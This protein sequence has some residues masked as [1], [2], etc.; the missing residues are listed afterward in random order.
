M[1][2]VGLG[3]GANAQQLTFG[4]KGGLNFATVTNMGIYDSQYDL[5]FNAGVFAEYKFDQFFGIAPEVVYSRQGVFFGT[6][7]LGLGP[8]ASVKLD[9]INVPVLVKLYPAKWLSIDLGPQL[10]LLTAANIKIGDAAAT[11]SKAYF[12]KVDFGLAM[13]LT[14]NLYKYIFLQGRYN[15]GLTNVSKTSTIGNTTM[16]TNSNIIT[17][18]VAQVGVGVRFGI[19]RE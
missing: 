4:P 8:S 16:V 1:L 11:D 19:N 3:A 6:A 10:G 18:G 2:F 9:Y 13:G 7:I 12:H 14:L 15:M 5:F 17:N